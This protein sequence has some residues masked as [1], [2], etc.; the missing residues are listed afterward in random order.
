MGDLKAKLIDYNAV[1][2]INRPAPLPAVRIDPTESSSDALFV[3]TMPYKHLSV[4]KFSQARSNG[5]AYVLNKV[6]YG[7]RDL[8]D[9]K[10]LMQY[11]MIHL[12]GST[13]TSN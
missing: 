1:G 2:D 6:S 7:W 9:F 5:T 10:V 12:S 11:I 4:D 13:S 8:A 3:R